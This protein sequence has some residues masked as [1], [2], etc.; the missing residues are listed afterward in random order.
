MKFLIAIGRI[1]H[2]Q[3]IL[4]FQETHSPVTEVSLGTSIG[5]FWSLTPLIGIQMY[6][7]FITWVILRIIKIRFYLPIA[8]A[9]I[10]ITNP[11]T[12]P[13]FY[14]L[15]YFVGKVAL[16]AIGVPVVEISFDLL[17]GVLEDSQSMDFFAGLK[18]WSLFLLDQ[19]GLPMF[20][21]GFLLGIPSA[22]IGYPIT[23]RLLN[24]YRTRVAAK[25]G[26]SLSEWEAKHVRKDVGLFDGFPFKRNKNAKPS[27]GK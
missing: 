2:R 24:A 21:G 10:W 22:I 9:M 17:W 25:E 7:G 14:Y 1:I 23:Y 26:L 11:V 5:L 8:I 3:I 16:V 18:H 27:E 19:M 15:F 13:F 12:M 6:L 20:T 4:P